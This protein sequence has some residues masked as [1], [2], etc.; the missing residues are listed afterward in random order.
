MSGKLS[1]CLYIHS[2]THL[3][4]SSALNECL[5]VHNF[6]NKCS[7]VTDVW[8][9]NAR[10]KIYLS[11]PFG[12]FC[13]YVILTISYM[14]EQTIE[15]SSLPTDFS[16][17]LFKQIEIFSILTVWLYISTVSTFLNIRK[18]LECLLGISPSGPNPC[19]GNKKLMLYLYVTPSTLS[20]TFAIARQI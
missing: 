19:G 6:Q 8:L 13:L 3:V 20:S 9:H 14:R 5:F 7:T 18:L 2:Y 17:P 12:I 11:G 1:N 10:H 15:T 4:T 16:R